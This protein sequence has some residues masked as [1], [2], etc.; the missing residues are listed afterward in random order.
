MAIRV[1]WETDGPFAVCDTADEALELLR[2]ARSLSNGHVMTSAGVAKLPKVAS[3]Q[4]AGIDQKIADLLQNLNER[5]KGLL[6]TLSQYPHGVESDEF[7]K[8]YGVEPSGL[9]GILA[10]LSKSAKKAHMNTN[11]LVTSE[12]RFE[13]TRRFRWIAP[14][15]LLMDNRERL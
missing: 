2:Q 7:S 1:Q 3:K 6:K 12:A 13:G 5:A 10:S 14:T 15:K 8:A 9:G 4:H 11:Q